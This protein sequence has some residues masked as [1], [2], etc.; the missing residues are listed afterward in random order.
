VDSAGDYSTDD[1][2]MDGD[3]EYST[4]NSVSDCST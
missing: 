1:S 4:D 2:A 3:S